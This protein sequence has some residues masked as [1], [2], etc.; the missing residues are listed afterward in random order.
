MLIITQSGNEYEFKKGTTVKEILEDPR[1]GIANHLVAGKLNNIIVSL[2]TKVETDSRIAPVSMLTYEGRK[3]YQESLSLILLKA[4]Y[5]IFPKKRIVIAHS[6]SREI[7]CNVH[8]GRPLRKA[9]VAQIKKRMK[10]LIDQ[11]LPF[12]EETWEKNKAKKYFAGIKLEDKVKF[13]T[14]LG[15]EKVKLSKLHKI[16]D[17]CYYPLL[18]STRYLSK[19]DLLCYPPGLVLRFPQISN[20]DTITKFKE[21]KPLFSVLIEDEAWSKILKV[22]NVGDLNELIAN[23]NVSDIIKIAEALQEKKIAE[24]ADQIKEKEGQIKFILIAGPSSSGKTTFSKRLSIQLRVNG[25]NTETISTDDYFKAREETPRDE[26]G[27]YD[28]ESIEALDLKLLNKHLAMLFK[29]KTIKVPK[30]NFNLGRRSGGTTVKKV[31]KDMPMIIEGIH[32]LNE[33]L[34][35]SITRKNKY[36]I[37]VSALTQLNIDDFNRIPTTDN[38]LLRRLVRDSLFRGYTALETIRRW[39]SVRKGEEKNIFPFQGRADIMF[40]SALNYELAV[41]KRYALPIL[42]DVPQTVPEY[43]EAQRIINF[44]TGFL[45]IGIKEIPH[46]SIIREFVGNS[47]FNY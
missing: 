44:L 24:I 28:F 20:P 14:Y 13:L 41:L 10:E 16:R 26:N 43:S 15:S 6:I 27:D 25:I 38:R 36:F 1:I 9:D 7:F 21:Q 2:S 32:C 47:S 11:D 31:P 3:I 42:K 40:N 22:K 8:I 23:K 17:I 46:N 45:S 35:S 4:F 19:F 39:S 34:T 18:P 12:K 37:Y 29:G 33:R 30:F 5:D